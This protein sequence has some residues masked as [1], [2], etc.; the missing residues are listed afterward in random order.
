MN[1]SLS[2]KN[3]QLKYFFAILSL[4]SCISLQAQVNVLD[5]ST[6]SP[7]LIKNAHS[8]KRDERIEFDVRSAGKAYYNIHQVITVLDETGKDEL[9]FVEF[10]DKF[11]GLEDVQI[12]VF[13]AGGKLLNKY[14]KK[15]LY[16]E[17]AGE[18]LVEDGKVY[19][20]MAS[21]ANYP[22]TVQYDYT[23]KYNGVLDYPD[24]HIQHAGESVEH[25]V[26]IVKVP[27]NLD[28]RYK[29]QNTNISPV[30]SV[31]GKNK[32]Y[33]WDVT[34]QPSFEWEEGSVSRE[35]RYPTI[36]LAPNK[37]ELEDYEGD[38]TSWTNFGKWYRQLCSNTINLDPVRKQFF[39]GLVK[40]LPT[41]REK[42]KAIYKYLQDNFRYVSIQLGIGGFRPFDASFT[43]SKKYGDCKGLSNYLQACLDAVGIKSY[44]ALI[45]ASYNKAPVD[46][47]FPHNSFNHVIL[48]VPMQKDSVWLECTSNTA[49]FGVLGNFTENRNALLIT[50]EGGKLVPTPRSSATNNRFAC[51]SLVKLDEN[52]GGV[53]AVTLNTSGEYKQEVVYY[54][55]QG[56]KDEQKK[57]IVDGLG[58]MQPDNFELTYDKQSPGATTGMQ[59]E[60]E[61]L[62]DFKA[63]SKL[64]LNPRLYRLWNYALPRSDNR[65]NDFYFEC[66]FI[67]TDTTIYQL[68]EN[69]ITETLPASK[70]LSFEYGSFSSSL[71]FDPATRA[72]TVITKLIL[73]EYH[74]PAA[75]YSGVKKFFDEVQAEYAEKIVIRKN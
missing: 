45:N 27:E 25:S 28:L 36:L 32:V 16:V 63:G 8:V 41:E 42:I 5:A 55:G 50:E 51:K 67:K 44:Q 59:M 69:Y 15:Q 35:S 48:C 18:G 4:A 37:F 56:K 12:Q 24:F 47:A 33:Q 7:A 19:H 70:N 65:K 22:V 61:K 23:L 73:N 43:D 54:I 58:F 72:I 20:F 64:F 74:I 39:Q 26:Y 3:K 21:G 34:N 40:D 49:D 66:P 52:G 62:F 75:R 71:Q 60:Y 13:D 38:M 68:P 11:H 53:A 6:L 1:R 9:E 14:S 31:D 10:T 57:F 30:V 46:P 2:K 29:Q 17:S